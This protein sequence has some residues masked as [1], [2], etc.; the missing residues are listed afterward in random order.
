MRVT[1]RIPLFLLGVAALFGFTTLAPAAPVTTTPAI[2]L[3]ADDEPTDATPLP[4]PSL[5]TPTGGASCCTF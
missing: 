5:D 4:T 3:R 1:T 2:E